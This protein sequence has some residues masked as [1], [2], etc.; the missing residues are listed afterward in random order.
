MRIVFQVHWYRKYI[1]R[2]Q[3]GFDWAAYKNVPRV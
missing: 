1:E 3:L 2:T